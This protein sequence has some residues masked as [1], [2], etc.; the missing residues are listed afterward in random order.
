MPN[1]WFSSTPEQSGAGQ[2][3]SILH[4]S[5]RLGC[6]GPGDGLSPGPL[7]LTWTLT[8]SLPAA[9]TQGLRGGEGLPLRKWAEREH[10]FNTTSPA[11][12]VGSSGFYYLVVLRKKKKRSMWLLGGNMLSHV[13]PQDTC[14]MEEHSWVKE[15]SF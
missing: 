5:E 6:W 11:P 2:T 7:R 13:R 12:V 4:A 15:F 10:V 14:L 9:E 1:D 3:K 8:I